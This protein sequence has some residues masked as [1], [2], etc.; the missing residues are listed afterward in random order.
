[1]SFKGFYLSPIQLGRIHRATQLTRLSNYVCG[2][3]TE[4][5]EVNNDETWDFDINFYQDIVV[6][7]GN[8]LTINCI[9]NM[10]PQ[11]KIIVEQN[12]K[13][14]IDGGQISNISN[15]SCNELWQGIEVWGIAGQ[16]QHLLSNNT[17]FQGMVELKNGA[18]I[19]NAETAISLGKEGDWEMN[20]T[21]GIVQAKN[22]IFKNNKRDIEFLKY[23]NYNQFI[24]SVREP[25]LSF[26]KNCN[27][28]TDA[29]LASSAIPSSHVTMWNVDGI[30]F[31]GCT[32]ENSNP[33]A[34]VGTL[35]KGIYT[36]DAN[37]IVTGCDWDVSCIPI[38]SCCN[39]EANIFKDLEIGIHATFS[40]GS[41]YNYNIDNNIFENCITNISNE[42]VNNA[43]ITRNEHII[44]F[45]RHT[46]PWTTGVY[47][48]TG[49]GFRIEENEFDLAQNPH[50]PYQVGTWLT[51]TG[52]NNNQVYKNTFTNLS[53]SNYAY[54]NN[55]ASGSAGTGLA[56]F[57]NKHLNSDMYDILV[58]ATNPNLGG[59][60][61]FQVLGI[62]N[63]LFGAGN[64]FSHTGNNNESDFMNNAP[65]SILYFYYTP[66]ASKEPIYY[67]SSNINLF[68]FTSSRNRNSC[69][70]NFNT[71][72]SLNQDEIEAITQLYNYHDDSFLS[73]KESLNNLL[74]GG[75]TALLISDIN[76]ANEVDMWSLQDVLFEYSPFLSSKVLEK[77]LERHD[78]FPNSIIYNILKNNPD[79][80]RHGNLLSFLSDNDHSLS[81]WMIDSLQERSKDFTDRSYIESEI[82]YHKAQKDLYATFIAHDIIE[83]NNNGN[84]ENINAN[85]FRNWVSTYQTAHG[86]YQIVDDYF[87][88]K[89]Y[90]EGLNFLN[91][92]QDNYEFNEF[93][94]DEYNNLVDLF[95]LI[96]V[97]NSSERNIFMLY[98]DEENTL[99]NIANNGV[100]IA[101]VRACNILSFVYGESCDFNLELPEIYNVEKINKNSFETRNLK[102]NLNLKIYPNPAKHYVEVDYEFSLENSVCNVTII[103]ILGKTHYQDK[104]QNLKGQ[105]AIDTRMWNNGIYLINI[106][107]NNTSEYF[108]DKFLIS[109]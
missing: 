47:F 11:A 48:N 38:G 103:D 60:R 44:G 109:K 53:H 73:K 104:I 61:P 80:I 77:V 41:Q 18:I 13:L 5:F 32:F 31:Y 50:V 8:T 23:Q 51:N 42:G 63:N 35:G 54:L 95:N 106:K 57:C 102:D 46:A 66:P 20:Y 15:N 93:E 45:P 4:A 2:Y 37:F 59:I 22:A 9:V 72:K 39:K 25:N 75:N 55:R 29:N 30:K 69:S 12:A 28:I 101:K 82:S 86:E 84:I 91:S 36:I 1:M 3:G 81:T 96:A 92:I 89:Q 34:T 10:S 78:L 107:S 27:F 70:S 16:H 79:A 105:I 87:G 76:L 65:N 97:V 26:F 17:R 49:S 85:D 7:S 19:E 62:N 83:K 108:T 24:P 88:K 71:K 56:Y 68:Q 43:I 21:G 67:S 14:I 33:N 6:K 100:G 58:D 94:L 40:N 64:E 74:D 52:E 90:N 99:R 98:E